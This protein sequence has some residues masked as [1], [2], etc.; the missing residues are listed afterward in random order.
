MCPANFNFG[1]LILSFQK[2]CLK[3][4]SMLCFYVINNAFQANSNLKNKQASNAL[5]LSHQ[6]VYTAVNINQQFGL[7]DCD[8][9][10]LA[11]IY[12]RFGGKCCLHFQIGSTD[13]C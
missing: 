13:F 10:K 9:V 2:K 3:L 4:L 5:N 12:H 7:P 8:A 6:Q 1:G 11:G